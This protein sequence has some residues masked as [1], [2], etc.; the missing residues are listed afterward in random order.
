M[1]SRPIQRQYANTFTGPGGQ[2]GEGASA[3]A[4]TGT[5]GKSGSNGNRRAVN[6]SLDGSKKDLD[7][8]QVFAFPEQC[9]MLLNK[10][11]RLFFTNG[12]GKGDVDY[13]GQSG[14]ALELYQKI[15]SRLSFLK[16]IKWD[17]ADPSKLAS[18]YTNLESKWEVTMFSKAQF[19]SILQ[20]AQSRRNR[21]LLGQDMWGHLENWAP[22]PSVQ[23]HDKELDRKLALLKDEESATQ[24]YE[25][26]REQ[27]NAVESY[28]SQGIQSM[29]K[30]KNEL[31]ATIAQLTDKNGPLEVAI[32]RIAAYT[33]KMKTKR[34]MLNTKIKGI[35][36]D[37]PKFD[38]DAVL[39]AISS[40]GSIEKKN[41]IKAVTGLPQLGY[42]LYKQYGADAPIINMEGKEVNR[43][44]VIDQLTTC[45]DTLESLQA[46]FST[47][48]DNTIEVDDPKSIKIITEVGN[49]KKILQ[50]FKNAI[51][52][53]NK[54][55]LEGELDAYV[56]LVKTRNNAVVQY[57]SDIQQLA[58]A[59]V[60]R[61]YYEQQI[62]KL[63]QKGFKIDNTLPY[64]VFWL[65]KCRDS[66]Q[67]NIM[68]LLNEQSRAIRFWGLQEKVTFSNPMPLQNHIFL[69]DRRNDLRTEFARTIEKNYAAG[70]RNTWPLPG[71][72]GLWRRLSQDEL[73][74]LKQSRALPDSRG[75]EHTLDIRISPQADRE[76]FESRIDIRL[77]QIRLWLPGVKMRAKEGRKLLLIRLIHLGD[78]VIRDRGSNGP[79]D[80]YFNHDPVTIN[81][82][83]DS[84]NVA[85]REQ[86][87][88]DV[89]FGQQSIQNDHYIG[90]TIDKPR[91]ALLGPF[92]TWRISIETD[93][94]VNPELDLSGVTEAFLEFHGTHRPS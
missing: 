77:S 36:F 13:P 2:G 72:Q 66:L 32:Y 58:E 52:Q 31:E 49:V 26:A 61:D 63:G 25:T 34:K 23:F 90:G 67:L 15:I 89:V 74:M 22:R 83:Y 16:N 71:K 93:Q 29:S 27:S 55:D 40:L 43:A 47:R 62:Q 14:S 64:I 11:N 68:Q 50:E 80:F 79:K 92:T 33:P 76:T 9:R 56:E 94:Y 10:A 44:Y 57:N 85:T 20:E 18:A 3:L 4:A 60:E 8:A 84:T 5:F 45:G 21:L 54:K 1:L 51:P 12:T 82:G 39:D 6:L 24:D 81:F 7:A 38:P 87:T 41:P 78:E 59:Y 91:L 65:R 88:S 17:E 19:G 70:V 48:K 75:R 69:S 46:S 28:V 37:K 35:Q 42:K 30:N 86:A 73:N 53:Y